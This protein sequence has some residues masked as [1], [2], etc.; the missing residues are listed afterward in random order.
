[1]IQETL[2]QIKKRIESSE[3]VKDENRKELLNLL[4][5]LENEIDQLSTTDREHA[6]SI[7]GFTQTSTHEAI[8]KDR[9][10]NL[11]KMS[12]E[13]LQASVHGFEGS[14]PKL[15]EI[16]NSISTALSNLGI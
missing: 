16:V 8:R 5:R 14:H 3:T 7:L 4:S 9:K 1:M 2:L 10:P 13:G 11:Q 15:V 12:L 6:E